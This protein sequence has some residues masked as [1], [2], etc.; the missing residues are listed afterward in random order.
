MLRA[1]L[2][3]LT[4]ASLLF[5]CGGLTTS[6]GMD[7]GGPGDA[8][9][10]SDAGTLLGGGDSAVSGSGDNGCAECS[11]ANGIAVVGGPHECPG[12]PDD[13][14]CSGSYDDLGDG[15]ARGVVSACANAAL[16]TALESAGGPDCTGVCGQGAI[17]V[18]LLS[19][20]PH[21]FQCAPSELGTLFTENGG[22]SRVRYT[23]FSAWSEGPLST[24]STCPDIAGAQACG[25]SCSPCS[26]GTE[27][28]GQS[29]LHPWG[30]CAKTTAG[31]GCAKTDVAQTCALYG[32][33]CFTFTVQAA[34]Q[35]D[36]DQ[37][38]SCMPPSECTA[39]ASGLPGG[40]SCTQ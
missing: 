33:V 12:G 3:I 37:N 17:C 22:G 18:Q 27:C 10:I 31:N 40:G 4:L 15:A 11:C 23:D 5:G 35:T 24:P 34:L 1:S 20:L 9:Y 21:T 2:S 38:G 28:K 25:G 26:S 16:M 30:Y 8:G 14:A 36:A 6:S 7:R 13:P 39:L 32:E 19:D 29:P